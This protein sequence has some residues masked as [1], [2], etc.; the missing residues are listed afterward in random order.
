MPTATARHILVATEQEVDNLINH[1][2]TG[3]SFEELARMYSKCPSKA[4]GGDLGEFGPGQMV[5]EFNDVCFGDSELNE[6]L[7][8]KTQFGWHLVQVTSRM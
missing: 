8:V 4:K 2:N 5:R 3:K 6:S 1:L 7:K